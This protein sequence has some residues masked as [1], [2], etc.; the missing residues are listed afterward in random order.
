MVSNILVIDGDETEARSLA[1]GL[2][3]HTYQTQETTTGQ[4][5][6]VRAACRQFDAVIL[7]LDLPDIG[8][9][10]IVAG[11]RR[12][13]TVPIIA[14]SPDRGELDKIRLLDAGADDHVTAPF[15]TGE[16]LARLRAKLR[17]SRPELGPATVATDDFT[18]DLVA[19]RATTVS[20]DIHLTPTEWR[21]VEVLTRN[22]G[23]MVTQRELL[24]QVWGPGYESQTEYIRVYLKQIRAKLEPVPSRPRYFLTY[25]GFGVRF[26]AETMHPGVV[27]SS[28]SRRRDDGTDGHGADATRRPTASSRPRPS[29]GS[30]GTSGG[31][32]CCVTTR[33]GSRSGPRTPP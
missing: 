6:L 13:T 14:I 20:G 10:E 19:R 8:G 1:H 2:R 18:I 28:G 27:V 33:T 25:P 4:D 31:R 29:I 26:D 7:G 5:G 15:A 12:A 11:L 21:L 22:R 32:R 16:L 3:A 17:R 24:L 9:V 23:S 30:S